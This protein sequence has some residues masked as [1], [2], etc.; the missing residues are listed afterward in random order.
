MLVTDG[1]GD[2][3]MKTEDDARTDTWRTKEVTREKFQSIIHN[4]M[5]S[6]SPLQ[7]SDE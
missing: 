6:S 4:F 3:K 7:F 5:L 2:G 1:D